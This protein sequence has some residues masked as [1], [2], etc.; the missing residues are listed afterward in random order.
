MRKLGLA[1]LGAAAVTGATAANATII[2]G[3]TGTTSGT[4]SVS[5]VDSPLPNRLQFDTIAA[6]PG[7]VTSF[8]TFM[9]SFP[10]FAT[11]AVTTSDGTITLEQLLTGGGSTV[12]KSVS[13]SGFALEL[14][15]GLL[16]ANTSYRFSYRANLPS[17]G[18]VSGTGTFTRAVPE[19]AT[20]A[21]MLLGFGGIG[22]AMRRR[23][24]PA[25]AQLA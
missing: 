14:K 3:A 18:N 8:F 4:I 22:F 16:A 6:A 7:S 12:I 11:F 10:S 19:P 5:N 23:R 21:L 25:L 9:E 15:T 2:I 13:G 1:L 20:W 17:G 24:Q